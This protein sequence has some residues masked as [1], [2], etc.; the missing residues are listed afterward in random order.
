M[1]E[2]TQPT[3][4]LSSNC[5]PMAIITMRK[6]HFGAFGISLPRISRHLINI[7]AWWSS[8]WCFFSIG[9]VLLRSLTMIKRF[10]S[11]EEET[12]VLYPETSKKKL[13]SRFCL[14]HSNALT[15][16]HICPL[17][18][19]WSVQLVYS[20]F[21]QKPLEVRWITRRDRSLWMMSNG[22][23]EFCAIDSRSKWLLPRYLSRFLPVDLFIVQ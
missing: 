2:K 18:T 19:Q 3:L 11:T 12:A 7:S 22:W 1:D 20:M 10:L 9:I 5:S 15:I 21:R 23:I 17:R 14:C 6:N 16:R 4:C 13:S 8:R